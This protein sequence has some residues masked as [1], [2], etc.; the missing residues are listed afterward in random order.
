MLKKIN[1]ELSILIVGRVLQ[2]IIALVAI[3]LATKALNAIEMGN[4][5]LILSIVTFFS[6]F[7]INPIGQYINRK[8]HEWYDNNM[9]LNIFFIYNIYILFISLFSIAIVSFLY[10]FGIGK[11]M[12]LFYLTIF[13]ALYIYFNTWNQTIIPMINMLE[14]RIAFV[15]FTILSHI[16]FLVLAI[17][18]I[19]LFGELAL[20]WFLGQ[21][22]GF[23]I[24]SLFALSYIFFFLTKHFSLTESLNLISTRNL[25]KV[26]TF[27]LPLAISVLFFWIQSQSY[28]LIIE[29]YIGAEFLGNFGV[30]IAIA[31]AI[32]GAFETIVMQYIYPKMYKSMNDKDDF[33]IIISQTIN[34]ITP[35][36]FLLAIF[37]AIFSVYLTVILVDTKFWDSY[38][39]IIFGIWISFFRMSSNLLANIAHSEMQTKKLI[40]PN[41]IS[42][43]TVLIGI[44]V[45]CQY[46]YY[47]YTIPAM[48]LFSSILYY[49]LMYQEMNKLLKIHFKLQNMLIVMLYSI[50]FFFGTFFYSYSEN[51]ITSISII[52]GFGLYFLYIMYIL[53]KKEGIKFD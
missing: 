48:L 51:I 3:K 47:E 1:K 26:L 12:D 45:L 34:L 27:I 49:L 9:L 8:T 5:Y 38:I 35:I 37:I 14:K 31:L 25:K 7:F 4:F 17:L 15:V 28:N 32:S 46:K 53:I 40:L 13:V 50:P 19:N 41:F 43:L 36:Y 10:H 39:Y 44:I 18:F 33:N 20:F 6:L 16:S 11:G 29:K 42:A 30:G 21:I 24:I 52:F 23:G 2:I 22:A